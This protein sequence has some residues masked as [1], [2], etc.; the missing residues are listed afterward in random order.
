[1]SKLIAS[2]AIRGAHEVAERAE[3]ELQLALET[4]GEDQRVEFPNTAYY[5]PVYYA[6]TGEKVETVGELRRMMD[7]VKSLLPSV[8]A[9]KM[10]MPYLGHTLDAGMAT[11]FADEIIESIKYLQDP[12]PY[13]LE[14]NCPFE[15]DDFWL[16]AANDIIFRARGI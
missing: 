4:Y 16:G 3:K 12:I 7:R 14:D 2:A 5:L 1:M 11:L 10:W 8:P 6:M 13:H 15:G 9:E